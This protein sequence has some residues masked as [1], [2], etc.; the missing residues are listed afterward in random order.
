AP[1][2]PVLFRRGHPQAG[3]RDRLAP[4]HALARRAPPTRRL[5]GGGA[6]RRSADRCRAAD[7]FRVMLSLETGP[8]TGMPR[9]FAPPRRI[10]M[11]LD[12]VGGVWRYARDLAA[13]LA[14]LGTEVV[15]A[16]FGPAPRDDQKDEAEALGHLIW[17]GDQLDWTVACEAQLDT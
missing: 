1:R 9:T 8:A 16:G 13:E 17:L 11:T 10:L 4:P 15:F 5:A 12:A 7:G 3:S 2:R 6:G 14:P